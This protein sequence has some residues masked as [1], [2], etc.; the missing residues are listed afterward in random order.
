MLKKMV[1]HINSMCIADPFLWQSPRGFHL[2]MHD[3]APFPFHKQVITYGFT[4]DPSAINGWR[5]SYVPAAN[6]T[7]IRFEDGSLH[8]FC[9]R[10]RPQIFFS[11]P[12]DF[13]G[14]QR[15]HPVVLFTGAQHGNNTDNTT[16]C[17]TSSDIVDPSEFNPYDDY[18]FTF[19]QPFMSA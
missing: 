18:S 1:Y 4:S 6:G 14:V 2:L 13:N 3:H 17:G 12:I 10:Q 15:G 8:T 5:F 7:N 19:S 11:Q 16:M 9:S